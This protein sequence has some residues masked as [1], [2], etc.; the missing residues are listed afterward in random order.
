MKYV[1][2]GVTLQ[3]AFTAC[4]EAAM[5]SPDTWG[6]TV[7]DFEAAAA[8]APADILAGLSPAVGGSLRLGPSQLLDA[9]LDA[10]RWPTNPSC[11]FPPG[12]RSGRLAFNYKL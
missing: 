4:Y 12:R 11:G 9:A 7:A 3:Q 2:E 5:R 6:K 10:A 8:R 1:I